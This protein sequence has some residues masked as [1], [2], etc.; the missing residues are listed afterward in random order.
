MFNLFDNNII[1]LFILL[2]LLLS[3]F[4]DL[5]YGEL[6]TW[7]H[8]VVAMGKIIDFY[9]SRLIVYRNRFSGF[10]LYV[11]VVLTSLI[12]LY[13]IMKLSQVN[14]ILFFIVFSVV[15]SSTFSI[16]LL[17]SSA[18]DIEH[19]LKNN[20]DDA[21]KAVSY[22]VSRN[23]EKL[24]ESF[25]VSA[26]IETLSE[27][28]TDSYVSPIFYYIIF[29]MVLII[30]NKNLFILLLFVPVIY[31]ISNT[32]DAM[33]GYETYELK[34]IGYFSAKVDDILNYIPARITGLFIV[35]AAY[36][37]KFNYK[38]CYLMYKRDADKCPSPNSGY[39]MATVAGALDIQLIKK[40]TYVLG[41]A[42]KTIESSDISAAIKLS[43]LAIT[44]FTLIIIIL[45]V[46]VYVVI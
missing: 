46:I 19:K 26:T 23:T 45:F 18:K 35:L 42:N 9:K 5:I 39:T 7:I 30:I 17:F 38:N 24:S 21:R 27:N 12:I 14:S 4:I 33:V 11:L 13:I 40:D 44:L 32:L 15:L 22:L 16:K 10:A 34:Y 8:P 41:D 1:F 2:S 37:L 43:K 6:P 20:I 31:R 28:I 29:G 3:L 36:M 25:I